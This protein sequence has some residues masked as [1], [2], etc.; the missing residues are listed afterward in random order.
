MHPDSIPIQSEGFV[1]CSSCGRALAEVIDQGTEWR[2]FGNSD[3]NKSNADPSRVGAAEDKLYQDGQLSTMVGHSK[4]ELPWAQWQHRTQA[5]NQKTL[6]K[7]YGMIQTLA[8][9]IGLES[10]HVVREAKHY[11]KTVLT[12]GTRTS[13]SHEYI[14]AACL[15]LACRNNNVAKPARVIATYANLSERD[16]LRTSRNL[17][18]ILEE[19][20]EVGIM[21]GSADPAEFLPN[22]CAELKLRNVASVRH[23]VHVVR[24]VLHL[25]DGKKPDTVAA[26]CVYYYLLGR[27]SSS[28]KALVAVG[29][30]TGA[31]EAAIKGAYRELY[32]VRAYLFD[33]NEAPVVGLDAFPLHSKDTPENDKLV[34]QARAAGL[35]SYVAVSTTPA[36]QGE[37]DEYGA[38]FNDTTPASSHS[39][40]GPSQEQPQVYMDVP[41]SQTGAVVKS[42]PDTN[43]NE[44]DFF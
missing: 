40:R 2:N 22:I 12:V 43:D 29:D 15:F 17:T 6:S 44:A 3:K 21:V 24:K 36:D 33:P 4:V 30:A 19:H 20:D 13:R 1:V 26:V 9:R 37:V 27:G 14:A 42:E 8:S 25:L 10:S 23:I 31:S 7:V 34:E 16:L 41:T 35:L 32:P 11:C 18:P 38:L 39:A 28:A 5:T